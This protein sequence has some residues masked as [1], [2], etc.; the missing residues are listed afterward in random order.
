[1]S[2]VTSEVIDFTRNLLPG[3]EYTVAD[4]KMAIEN[5][6]GNC[7]ARGFVIAKALIALGENPEFYISKGHG[8]RIADLRPFDQQ[9]ARRLD[10][11]MKLGE[12][13]MGHVVVL[14][15]ERDAYFEIN[16]GSSDICVVGFSDS[17][18]VFN[19]GQSFTD[20]LE[21]IASYCEQHPAS[22]TAHSD[23]LDADGIL[24]KL[25]AER[26]GQ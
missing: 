3:F 5:G 25:I 11:D 12:H 8:Q 23:I 18:R 16:T 19:S 17:Q 7:A 26:F 10:P 4:P 24:D 14:S 6:F 2:V 1:M 22:L 13:A 21:G 20:P 9:S 15:P